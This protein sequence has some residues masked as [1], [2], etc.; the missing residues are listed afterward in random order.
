MKKT[1]LLIGLSV[2]FLFSCTKKI[3]GTSEDTMKSSIEEI[4]KS[5]N[6]DKKKEF[7]ESLQLIM[8]H[9]LDFGKMF[10]DDGAEI[11]IKD[12]KSKIDGMTA[13]DIIAEGKRIK[14]EVERKKK[15]QAKSE[16]E[17]LYKNKAQAESD[18]KQL[19]KFEVKRSRF[20]I[21]KRDLLCERGAHN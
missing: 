10:E 21:K 9:G 7:E 4:K 12:F 17:E 16:I 14:E 2:F 15:E 19:E 18:R 6:D 1:I 13:S 5:L 20:Y 8:F 3:D 11:T